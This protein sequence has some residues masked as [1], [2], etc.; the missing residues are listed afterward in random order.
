MKKIQNPIQVTDFRIHLSKYFQES[1][2][3]PLLVTSARGWSRVLIDLDNYNDL[4][5]TYEDYQDSITLIDKV[6]KD[7]WDYISIDNL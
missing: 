2:K 1:Q 7:S 5:E 3:T 4:I 6:D